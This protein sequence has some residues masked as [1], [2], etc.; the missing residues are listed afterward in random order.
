[1][2]RKFYAKDPL[3]PGLASSPQHR[4]VRSIP[5][6][7][8]VESKYPRIEISQDDV[9]KFLFERKDREFPDDK[10]ERN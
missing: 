3:Q 6:T 4:A 8:P 9:W 5:Y 2:A 10:G 7:M 1:M